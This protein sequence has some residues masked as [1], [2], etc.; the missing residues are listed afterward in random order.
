MLIFYQSTSS[1]LTL[2]GLQ[3]TGW[4]NDATVTATMLN[5]NGTPEP[6]FDQIAG[7]YV[8]ESNGDYTFTP[9]STLNPPAGGNY[10]V[11]VKATTPAG[12]TRT[13]PLDCIVVGG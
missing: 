2:S 10:L 8:P 7:V 13:W 5:P 6:G 9:S 3:S 12:L 1:V 11:I 4:E